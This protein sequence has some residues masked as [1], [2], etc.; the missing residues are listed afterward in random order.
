MTLQND[1]QRIDK[2]FKDKEKAINAKYLRG[3][4]QLSQKSIE[5]IKVTSDTFTK[6]EVLLL[7]SKSGGLVF[8][9]FQ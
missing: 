6:N 8:A 3:D 4:K 1:S 9:I 2:E 5:I 7:G